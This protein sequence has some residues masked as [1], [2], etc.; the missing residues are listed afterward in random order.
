MHNSELFQRFRLDGLAVI[1][2][3]PLG[4]SIIDS[5]WGSLPE[6]K[7]SVLT[8][9]AFQVEDLKRRKS[10]LVVYM[11]HLWMQDGWFLEAV[12][13]SQKCVAACQRDPATLEGSYFVI[14]PAKHGLEVPYHQDA[15][16]DTD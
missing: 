1:D 5:L 7:A 3:A 14:K 2:P 6:L 11:P 15:M 4:T 16:L 13:I 12:T 10:L 8:C 9:N